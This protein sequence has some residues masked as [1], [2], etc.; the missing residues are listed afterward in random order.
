M[1]S[2]EQ[3]KR[4]GE[5]IMRNRSPKQSAFLGLSLGM[6]VFA[7]TLPVHA[8][9]VAPSPAKLQTEAKAQSEDLA[10]S[11]ARA[12]QKVAEVQKKT[13]I[14]AADDQGQEHKYNRRLLL[15]GSS[16]F[17]VGYIPALVTVLANSK[18]T[19]GWLGVPVVGPWVDWG[20][21]TSPGNKALLFAS[22]ALQ[23]V[24]LVGIVSSFFVPES[25]TRNMKGPMMGRRRVNVT[26]VAGRGVYTLS[27][28]GTF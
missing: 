3:I 25:K 16:L 18:G 6:A 9:P 15:S 8:Q 4:N 21:H 1:R 14:L 26:P 5:P 20:P 7:T 24:G 2:A 11:N 12:S 22:G 10:T 17:A 28:S 27:A 13:I 23:A 19:S